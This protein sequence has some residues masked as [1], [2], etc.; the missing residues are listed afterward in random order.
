MTCAACGRDTARALYD[1]NGFAIVQCPCGLARTVLPEGFDPA[2]IYSE[3][4]FQGGRHDGYADYASSA[5]RPNSA[6]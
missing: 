1:V 3:A 5:S 6:M 4:Y 2:A